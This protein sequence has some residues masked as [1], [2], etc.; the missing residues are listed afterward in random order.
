MSGIDPSKFFEER[1]MS[2]SL[3]SF[4]IVEG[5]FLVKL[6][7]ESVNT[8]I[9]VRLPMDSGIEPRKWLEER[10]KVMSLFDLR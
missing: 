6:L 2:L 10:S 8:M 5:T 7:H 3:F 4:P 1:D 9:A